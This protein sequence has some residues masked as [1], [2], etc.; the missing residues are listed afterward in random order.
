MYTCA[1]IFIFLVSGTPIATPSV[2]IAKCTTESY[3]VQFRY[4]T[5]QELELQLQREYANVN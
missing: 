2:D 5:E 4:E 1:S 3:N